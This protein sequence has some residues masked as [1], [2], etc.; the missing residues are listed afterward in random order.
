MPSHL[1]NRDRDKWEP[2]F[3]IASQLGIQYYERLIKIV[4]DQPVVEDESYGA[5]FL[6]RSKKVYDT[7]LH[8]GPVKYGDLI[9]S[10]NNHPNEEFNPFSNWN[11]DQIDD[12]R[13]IRPRQLT[14]LLKSYSTK[15]IPKTHRPLGGGQPIRGVQWGDILDAHE[16]L[17]EGP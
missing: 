10:V 16:R 14:A 15:L 4:A 5:E 11:K 8:A 17:G 12:E 7:G 13:W 3:A 2:L 1:I 9:R 6:R